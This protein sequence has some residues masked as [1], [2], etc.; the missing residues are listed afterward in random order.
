MKKVEPAEVKKFEKVEE[1]PLPPP[2]DED[3][4]DTQ[5]MDMAPL[6]AKL[7]EQEKK[8]AKKPELKPAK[9]I[10][11][12]VDGARCGA[13]GQMPAACQN[14]HSLVELKRP[15]LLNGVQYGP[16]AVLAP[17]CAMSLFLLAKE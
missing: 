16:G 5:P 3:V 6:L 4:R 12:G 10:S 1:K 7:E 11:S 17:S 15:V 2:L 14:D 9:V 8:A 13:C